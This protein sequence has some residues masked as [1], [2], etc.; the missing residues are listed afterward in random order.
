MLHGLFVTGTDTGVGKTA[1]AAA[2]LHRYRASAPLRY[3]K[4]IQTGIE[5]D[6]DTREVARLGQ[7]SPEE[8]CVEGVRLPRP[9]SPYV[10][11]RL[12]G[13]R[14]DVA[15][16]IESV[17]RADPRVRWIVEGAGGVLVPLNERETM[18]DLMSGL[19]MPVIVTARTA[20]GTI[21]HTL[22]TLEALRRR[23]IPIAGVVLVG[24]REPHTREAIEE[25]GAVPIVGEM[26]RFDDLTCEA[27]APWARTNLDPDGRL[28]E[29]L[30]WT[31]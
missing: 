5:R 18:A 25:L 28:S 6:D 22:L 23:S 21:N 19:A 12:S 24:S 17:A 7:A 4:P 10:A 3:W 26:P 31:P 11:A 1:V 16:L 9:L 14:I 8:L 15:P 29:C 30:R 20:L 27:L 2:L 13:C